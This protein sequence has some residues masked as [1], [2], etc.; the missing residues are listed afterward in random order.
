LLPVPYH[1]VVFTL[2]PPAAEIAFQNKRAVYAILFRA[3][4]E[5]MRD[6][7]ADPRAVSARGGAGFIASRLDRG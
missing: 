4:A 3:A 1:R 2:P 6:I 7:T 5:A